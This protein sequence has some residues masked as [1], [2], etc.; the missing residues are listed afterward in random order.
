MDRPFECL[1]KR[2]MLKV[3]LSPIQAPGAAQLLR[4]YGLLEALRAVGRFPG[5]G[6]RPMALR[7][8]AMNPKA[9]LPRV[10][11]PKA[12]GAKTAALAKKWHLKHLST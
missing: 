7:S 2:L 10:Q 1:Q 8:I 4:R 11:D 6:R 12:D 9:P 3:S 5:L